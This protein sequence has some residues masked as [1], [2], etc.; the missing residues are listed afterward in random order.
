MQTPAATHVNG[1]VAI[2]PQPAVP[3]LFFD[4]AQNAAL[5]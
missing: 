2:Y 1:V 3:S 5:S 4:A